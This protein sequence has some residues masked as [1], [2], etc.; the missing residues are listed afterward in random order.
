[1]IQQNRCMVYDLYRKY[2][3]SIGVDCKKTN[4]LIINDRFSRFM[5]D[6]KKKSELIES[7]VVGIPISDIYF[8]E[9]ANANLIVE[10]GFQRLIT[11]FAY[12]DNEFGLCGLTI[13]E[14]LNGKKFED[15]PPSIQSIIEDYEILA[16]TI[17]PN[18]SQ[19]M[20]QIIVE[21][22]SR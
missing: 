15:L 22:V 14:D 21:R 3:G 16:Q 17:K 7:I 12:L 19:A 20:K 4:Q 9:D 18:I 10:D 6:S 13:R 11:L 1:M 2:K 5:W 8:S